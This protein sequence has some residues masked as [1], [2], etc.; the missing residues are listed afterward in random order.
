ME[1]NTL[2]FIL[3]QI[4]SIIANSSLDIQA[5]KQIK[6]FVT[7]GL[8]YGSIESK[9]SLWNILQGKLYHEENES[10]VCWILESFFWQQQVYLFIFVTT[11]HIIV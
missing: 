9:S 10:I 7:Y 3:Q 5:L 8:C 1:Q 2:P 4:S 6:P 11:I